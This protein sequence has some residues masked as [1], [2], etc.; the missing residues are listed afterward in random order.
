MDSQDKIIRSPLIQPR[1]LL[2]KAYG[3]LPYCIAICLG[4]SELRYRWP[5]RDQ[6]VRANMLHHYSTYASLIYVPGSLGSA[7]TSR[8]QSRVHCGQQARASAL[9]SQSSRQPKLAN[10]LTCNSSTY[11]F[12]AHHTFI[13]EHLQDL[14]YPLDTIIHIRTKI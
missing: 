2:P 13:T 8:V 12:V 9:T 7:S 4:L 3:S 14:Q 11:I 6:K 10:S 1:P 5:C